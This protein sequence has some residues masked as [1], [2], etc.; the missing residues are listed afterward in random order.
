[1]LRG[2]PLIFFRLCSPTVSAFPSWELEDHISLL[3]GWQGFV[4]VF[5]FIFVFSPLWEDSL[6]SSFLRPRSNC[7]LFV[8]QSS[9]D[10]G[11]HSGQLAFPSPTPP[12]QRNFLQNLAQTSSPEDPRGVW[13]AK[14]DPSLCHGS[15][16]WASGTYKVICVCY[17]YLSLQM[18]LCNFKKRAPVEISP[19]PGGL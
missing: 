3:E 9:A 14:V 2:D 17:V 10:K 5:V 6:C 1:M 15:Q 12:E 4:F 19:V 8:P 11:N 13:G 18:S 16:D 7:D